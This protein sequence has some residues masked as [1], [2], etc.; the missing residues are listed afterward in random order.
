MSAEVATVEAPVDLLALLN[1]TPHSSAPVPS[2][3][4]THSYLNHLTSLPLSTLQTEPTRL[5]TEA[6]LLTTDLTQL[7]LSQHTTFLSLHSGSQALSS[8]LDALTK[9]LDGLLGDGI[10]A[11]EKEAKRF[12]EETREIQKERKKASLVLEHHDKLLDL[13]EL[14][15]LL[16]TCVQNGYYAE[17]LDLSTHFTQNILPSALDPPLPIL[18][19]IS[20]SVQSSIQALLHNL[21][22]QLQSPSKLPVL[23]R[24]ISLLRKMKVLEEDELAMA[25][26]YGRTVYLDALYESATGG[27]RER[28]LDPARWIRKWVE[29][30]REG[31]YDVVTQFSTIFLSSSPSAA[32]LRPLL[33][34]FAQT[35]LSSLLST[36]RSTIPLIPPAS[37]PSLSSLQTQLTYCSTSFAR[38]GLDFKSLLDPIVE[39]GVIKV[40]GKGFE[41]AK[42]KLEKTIGDNEKSRR[43]GLDWMTTSSEPPPPPLHTSI[44]PIHTP[45][46]YLTSYPPLAH[47]TNSILR[48]YNSLRLL[49]LSPPR[50]LPRLI[51]TLSSIFISLSSSL[52]AYCRKTID[53]Q[54]RR[55]SGDE[56]ERQKNLKI[57]GAFGA[58]FWDTVRY[59]RAA[60]VEGVFGYTGLDDGVLEERKEWEE[61]FVTLGLHTLE[62]SVDEIKE[63]DKTFVNGRRKGSADEFG[64]FEGEQHDTASS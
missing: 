31:V 42:V 39:E 56:V 49:T 50:V 23:F 26:L 5:Q 34:T 35:N 38:I 28:T 63:E 20:A 52:L 1:S 43:K 25:F 62:R 45:P 13:L 36:L 21:L 11:L 40:V 33:L 44:T 2:T 53:D 51:S 10:P 8:S 12:A 6:N 37:L 61:W 30:F 54:G 64:R 32:D 14:P 29:V 58:A 18:Q 4:A 9:S 57:V 3:S 27:E 24:T 41:E 22:N 47:L 17:A 60:L 7:C 55:S 19:S 59:A 15:H 46:H 16:S 48:L